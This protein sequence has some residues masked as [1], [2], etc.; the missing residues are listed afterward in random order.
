[1]GKS[2]SANGCGTVSV[3]FRQQNTTIALSTGK[4]T[5]V[6]GCE[7]MFFNSMQLTN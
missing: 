1:M 4:N 3:N 6:L 2:V 7:I 5:V